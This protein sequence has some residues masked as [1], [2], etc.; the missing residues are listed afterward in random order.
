MNN[1]DLFNKKSECLYSL[2]EYPPTKN[3]YLVQILDLG[4]FLPRKTKPSR[5][6][7]DQARPAFPIHHDFQLLGREGTKSGVWQRHDGVRVKETHPGWYIWMHFC[8]GPLDEGAERDHVQ[9]IYLVSAY[10]PTLLLIL[11]VI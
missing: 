8:A 6:P 11:P 3:M 4:G 7:A 1:Q 9:K 10:T 5:P 2:G